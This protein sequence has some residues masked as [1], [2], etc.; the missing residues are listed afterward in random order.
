[1]LS[2]CHNHFM[3][4]IFKHME[5][6]LGNKKSSKIYSLICNNKIIAWLSSV[7]TIHS[8]VR[9]SYIEPFIGMLRI[10]K[11]S[12]K[13][14]LMSPIHYCYYM[15]VV[16]PSWHHSSDAKHTYT[17]TYIIINNNSELHAITHSQLFL[18]ILHTCDH[19]TRFTFLAYFEDCLRIDT[20]PNIHIVEIC[21]TVRCAI[22]NFRHKTREAA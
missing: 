2:R 20:M 3:W 4:I 17:H 1:M 11:P 13:H 18:L 10:I 14:K 16:L 21:Y 5:H 8:I 19:D 7:T 12:F 22:V 15:V 6:F 9:T